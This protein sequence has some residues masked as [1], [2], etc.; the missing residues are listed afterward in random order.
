MSM[1]HPLCADFN[2]HVQVSQS[3]LNDAIE[4]GEAKYRWQVENGI[5]NSHALSDD[6]ALNRKIRIE[7]AIGEFVS[8][9][10]LDLP[11]PTKDTFPFTDYDAKLP[12]GR[13][14][15]FKYLSKIGFKPFVRKN[16]PDSMLMFFVTPVVDSRFTPIPLRYKLLGFAS[17]GHMRRYGFE[18]DWG[19]GREKIIACYEEFLTP[20]SKLKNGS[21]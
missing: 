17:A 15:N 6:P 2:Q 7:G 3:I 21:V 12:D 20:A 9:S 13:M 5:S 11:F 8:C 14:I 4:F 1:F 18:T 10:Y 16:M 19:N